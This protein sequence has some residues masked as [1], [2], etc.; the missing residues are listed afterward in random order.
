MGSIT[1]GKVKHAWTSWRDVCAVHEHDL[2][3]YDCCFYYSM[4]PFSMIPS[5]NDGSFARRR[6]MCLEFL[7]FKDE[8]PV[9]EYAVCICGF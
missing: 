9:A 5:S 4:L 2:R 7:L 1:E 8:R 3:R 6:N